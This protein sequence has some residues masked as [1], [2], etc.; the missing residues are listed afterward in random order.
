MCYTA[1]RQKVG[2]SKKGQSEFLILL[3]LLFL[4]TIDLCLK[5][6]SEAKLYSEH[7]PR[8]LYSVVGSSFTPAV[9]CRF[10]AL[11]FLLMN[12]DM[13]TQN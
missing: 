11:L 7:K 3:S 5:L 8:D 13:A 4:E 9:N 1:V 6:L 10:I 12:E 2:L